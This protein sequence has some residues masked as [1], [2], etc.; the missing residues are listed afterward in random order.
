MKQSDVTIKSTCEL[1][2]GLTKLA[3]GRANLERKAN[4]YRKEYTEHKFELFPRGFVSQN[5]LK[6]KQVWLDELGAN[7]S[8]RVNEIVNK[9]DTSL[10]VKI[11]EEIEKIKSHYDFL[12]SEVRKIRNSWKRLLKLEKKIVGYSWPTDDVFQEWTKRYEVQEEDAP[13]QLEDAL[14]QLEDVA[15]ELPTEKAVETE[16]DL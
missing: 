5:Q 1:A 12:E 10:F 14:G 13:E 15:E 7:L 4:L 3:D 9:D 2:K 6:D 8:F 11:I 16:K